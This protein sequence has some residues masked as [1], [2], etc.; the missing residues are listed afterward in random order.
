[1]AVLT[2]FPDHGE[3]FGLGLARAIADVVLAGGKSNPN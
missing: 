3:A 2:A 1:M